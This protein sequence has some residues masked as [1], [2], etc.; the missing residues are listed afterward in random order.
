MK[1][2]CLGL[3]V[4]LAGIVGC[5]AR[6]NDTPPKA[7]DEGSMQKLDL[8]KLEDELYR[9][10][11]AAFRRLCEAHPKDEFYCFAFYTNGE[12]NYVGVT[13][14][15]Y[16]GLDKVAQ[17]Y[18]K[19]PPYMAMSIEDLRLDLKWSPCD[20][21][22]HDNAENDLTALDSLMQAVDAE[23]SRRFDLK[24][25]GK[26]FK[27]F[28]AQVRGC[29]A[30]ALKRIDGEGVFGSGDQRKKV[31]ANLLM[32]DQSDEDRIGFAARVNP[33]ESVK[34]LKQDLEAASRLRR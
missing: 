30:S 15:T 6:S 24:D 16:Q 11:V 1:P 18:K 27:E 33:S 28:E 21:P 34:M 14:S 25:D 9:H 12:M 4:L 20:S 19:K 17:E 29:F 13:A 3:L 26:S 8:K 32:G 7:L 22:L 31:V 10:G 5:V 2:A 23:L